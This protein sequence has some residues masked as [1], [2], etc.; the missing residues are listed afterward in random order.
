MDSALQKDFLA[1]FPQDGGHD[2]GQTAAEHDLNQALG[3]PSQA[4]L[5]ML[6]MSAGGMPGQQQHNMQDQ[7]GSSG[8]HSQVNQ[9][10]LDNQV[11]FARLKL[12]QVQQEILQQQVCQSRKY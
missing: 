4:N 9:A 1:L 7:P 2:G 3:Y 5:D 8:G 10:A 11:K 12:L 6:L